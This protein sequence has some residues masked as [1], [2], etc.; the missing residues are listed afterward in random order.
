MRFRHLPMLVV[1]AFVSF[2]GS[3]WADEGVTINDVTQL[4]PVKARAV[5]EPTSLDEIVDVVK[6]HPGPISVGGGRYSMGGQTATENTLQIDMRRF[7]KVLSFSKEHKTITVQAGITWRKILEYIDPHDLSLQIMQSYANFTVGGSLSVNVHGR[8]IG[9]G[10]LVMSVKAIRLVLPDGTVVRAS[11]N[12]RAELFY[13]AIGGY[14]ALGVI[15]E[16]TLA[17]TDN[18]RVA[19]QSTTMPLSAYKE[20]FFREVRDSPDVVFHN[21]D[22]YP[23]AYDTVRA[24]SYVRTDQPATVAERLRPSDVSHWREQWALWAV[25]EMPFG[26]WLRRAVFDPWTYR[27]TSVVWRNYEASYDVRELEPKSRKEST[28]VLQEYFVPVDQ[29]DAFVPRMAETLKRHDVNVVNISIRHAKKDPGTLLAWARSEVFAFVLYYKQGTSD[30]D[31]RAV[32]IWTRQL[33]DDVL[34]VGGTYYLPYQIHATPTQFRAAYPKADTFFALKKRIDP[35]NKF[36]NKLWDAYYEDGRLR[37]ATSSASAVAAELAH[38]PG[39]KRDE[40]QTYLTLPEWYLVYSPAEYA[41]FVRSQ[42]PAEFPYFAA[43][44]QFWRYYRDAYAVTKAEHGFNWGYHVMVSVIGSSFTIENVIKGM[45]ENTVGRLSWWIA[46]EATQEDRFAARVAQEYVDFLNATPWYEFP[47]AT[48]AK[49]LWAE[50]DLFG[51][52]SIRKWERKLALSL[53]YL[54]KAQYATLIRLAT[55]ATYGDADTE[56]LALVEG[57]TPTVL[58][59][60][61]NV[62]LL[63]R[64]DDG[65]ALV[66]LPRYEEFR[67]VTERLTHKGLR[68]R[69]IAGND[70]ILLTAVVPSDWQYDLPAG[71]MLFAQP[72]LT[73]PNRSLQRA[74]IKVPVASLHVALDGLRASGMVAEHIYDY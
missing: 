33:I 31:R 8:Y 20:Y 34:S 38:F 71:E 47:F 25:S 13:G 30:A 41:Q 40:A 37:T 44:G 24:T 32:G 4:N 42:P 17:L 26:G 69:E 12:E 15:A 63:R 50:T 67:V 74:A 48:R 1:C 72:I 5:I 61:P 10:P 51:P 18:V 59:D 36:R 23:D 45:Y 35:T 64:F 16:A 54:A 70:E 62:K 27:G 56:M 49:Q 3:A 68:F 43:V 22:I 65:L 73:S 7:D 66:S 52:G 29:L 39:Y 21:A 55:K 57:A 6:R 53:E 28:Y 60:Q 58:K 14:G 2:V 46:G 11:P 19:R 9:L